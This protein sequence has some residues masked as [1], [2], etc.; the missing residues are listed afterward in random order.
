M[1]EF[2]QKQ[3]NFLLGFFA[4]IAFFRNVIQSEEIADYAG[5]VRRCPGVVIAMAIILPIFKMSNLVH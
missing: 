1:I 2:V 3:Q 4:V 5:L